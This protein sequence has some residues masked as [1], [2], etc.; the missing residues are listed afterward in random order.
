MTRASPSSISVAASSAVARRTGMRFSCA[1]LCRSPALGEGAKASAG[2]F[3]GTAAFRAVAP[4]GRG[5]GG[6]GGGAGA[7]GAHP[8]HVGA[9]PEETR[10]QAGD[11][12][13]HVQ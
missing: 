2:R 3:A 4:G 8:V 6:R 1:F 9:R 12:Q 10:E 5:L 7:G 11:A 13:I